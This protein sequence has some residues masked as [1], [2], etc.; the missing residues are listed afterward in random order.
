M[1][2]A[3]TQPA[4]RRP[5]LVAVGALRR[6]PGTRIEV[7]VAAPIDDMA[8]S[9]SWVPEGADV[10]FDGAVESTIGGVT[11]IGRVRAPVEGV[12]RRCLDVARSELDIAIRELCVDEPDPE[13]GYGVGPEWLDLEPI[14][15][16]ACI[17]EL[18]LAPLCR[19]D[20]QGLCAVCGANRNRETCSCET[21]LDPRWAALAG[22]GSEEPGE[23]DE[24]TARSLGN[25]GGPG[26]RTD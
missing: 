10:H 2:G 25:G 3:G 11:V 12:C 8:V 18:P 4:R 9:N 26:H 19:D 14:V 21:P 15:R 5:W 20:C 24:P 1:S 6:R 7:A 23:K 13:L 22:L 16:D 17:L